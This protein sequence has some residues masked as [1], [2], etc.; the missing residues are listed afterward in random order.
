MMFK[1]DS[2]SQRAWYFY[3]WANSAYVTTVTT[4]LF[5]PYLTSVAQNA[6]GCVDDVC[7][8][9]LSVLG[10]PVA[11][12]SLFFY[13]I[14]FTTL[15]S[16]FLLPLV[17]AYADLRH[18]KQKLMAKFAW[19]GATAAA[20]M[21][22]VS[23]SN[24][25]LGAVLLIIGNLALGG[26][27]VVYDAI[28][29]DIASPDERDRVSSRGWAFGYVGGGLLLVVNLAM[30]LGAPSEFTE[31][32]IRI[33]LLSAGLW[34][35][36][37]TLIPY[38]RIANTAEKPH[39]EVPFSTLAKGSFGQLAH[40]LRELSHYPQTRLFLL[41]Y[42]FFNDGVQTVIASASVYG[43]EEL[44]LGQTELVCAIVI[45]QIVAIFGAL[46]TG[47]LASRI[48]AYRT[49][50]NSLVVWTVVIIAGYFV[51]SERATFFYLLA[52]AIGFILGGTQAL[53]RSL[54]SQLVPRDREAEYFALYQACERG[55]SW[56]GTLA[57]GLV[58]QLSGSYRPAILVLIVFFL[59]GG[60]LLRK[61]DVR[62]GIAEAGNTQPTVA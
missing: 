30:Y 22:F 36:L 56:L 4:V 50:L 13:L 54:F 21:F 57:F 15:I 35:G 40:T 41:A 29:C 47:R 3:D 10:L 5:G 61:V 23:G 53:S 26:S 16:A 32:A 12:G 11:P 33:S 55:T 20:L 24:W 2:R 52:A 31:L 9:N 44:K 27:L 51:P 45:V 19:V 6:A 1:S 48:G 58:Y 42:L 46:F 17:G 14:T 60:L 38:F 18:D 39:A 25:Q 49:V 28:L 7:T 43:S 8:E 59:V 34:W 37:W 62:A